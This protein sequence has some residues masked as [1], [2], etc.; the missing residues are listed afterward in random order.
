MLGKPIVGRVS[1]T[2]M[3]AVS[4]LAGTAVNLLIDGGATWRAAQ[5]LPVRCWLLLAALAVVCTAIGYSIWFVII[6][7]C[8]IN[9]AALTIFAQSVFGVALASFWLGEKSNWGQL[10]GSLTIAVGLA[11]GLSRQIKSVSAPK[12]VLPTRN[13]S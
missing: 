3:L 4:L 12:P 5:V 11:F 9:V 6:R 13:I 10:A 2:K 7:D 1:V 8:P